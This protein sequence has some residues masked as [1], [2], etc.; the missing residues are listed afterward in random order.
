MSEFGWGTIVDKGISTKIKKL[1]D[2]GIK[3]VNI[4]T[5]A[6][7]LTEKKIMELLD[8]RLDDIRISLDAYSKQTY[9]EIRRGLNYDIVKGNV[10]NLIKIRN[11][12]HSKMEIRIRMVELDENFEERKEWMK[13]WKSKLGKSDKVQIMPMHTWSQKIVNEKEQQIEF[14]S[15]KPCVSVFSSFAINYD[16]EVQLCDSDVEQQYIMGNIQENSIKEI[17]Q[18]EKFETIRKYHANGQRNQIEIC[19]GCNHWSRYFSEEI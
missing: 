12:T 3:H 7:L 9:E 18:S 11:D 5:N 6:S 15:D 4:S 16:G 2:I 1:K 14:Y 8:S 13:Y 17:W 19:K 10:L